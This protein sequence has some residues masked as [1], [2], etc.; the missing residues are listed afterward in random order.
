MTLV[1]TMVSM[2][3][4]VVTISGTINGYILSANRA[5]WSSQSLAAHSMV[6]QR[7]EQVRSAKWD[8][9]AYPPVDRVVPASFPAVTNVLDIPVSGTNIVT[10]R[11]I[12]TVSTV[13]ANP[14][15]K[16]IRVDCIWPYLSRGWFTNTMMSYRS[17]DQ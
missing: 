9:A 7:M 17:P 1:E 12:T 3:I 13:S 4:A 10:A 8:T 14:P 11:V 16:M 2:A 5:A 6:M 15:L